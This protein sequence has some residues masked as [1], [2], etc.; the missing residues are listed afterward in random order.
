MVNKPITDANHNP[1]GIIT[2]VDVGNDTWSGYLMKDDF[3]E[4]TMDFQNCTSIVVKQLSRIG[5]YIYQNDEAQVDALE[6]V[7]DICGLYVKD[8]D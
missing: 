6:L 2:E 3:V 1:I 7:A 4:T 8:G 5:E